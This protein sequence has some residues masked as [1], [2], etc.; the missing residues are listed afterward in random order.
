[1]LSRQTTLESKGRETPNARFGGLDGLRAIAVIMVFAYHLF[2]AALPGGFLGVDVFFTISGFLIAS[3]LIREY[4]S[5]GRISLASFWRRRARRLLPALALVVLVSTALSL[6]ASRDLL[7][8]IAKQIA[9]AVLFVSNWV[10]VASGTDYFER[11][12]PELFRNLWSLA[13][14]EQFY[15][16]LPLLALILFRFRSKATKVLVLTGF[17]VASAVLMASHATLG[18]DATRVYFGS[19]THSFGLLLG[20][21]MALLLYAPAPKPLSRGK[22]TV[23]LIAATVGFGVLG[24][25]AFTLPEASEASFTG[26]FQLATAAA[27]LIVGA[28]TREGAWAGRALDVQPLRWIGER[29]YGIYLWHWPLLLI[30]TSLAS[31]LAQN[32]LAVWIVATA[33]TLTTIVFAALSYR[34]VEQPVRQLGLR[35][36]FARWFSPRAYTRRQRNVA[37]ALTAVLAICFPLTGIAVAIAPE[38]S[39]SAE[40][41][42]RGQQLLEQHKLQDAAEADRHAA[43][44][45]DTSE[46]PGTSGAAPEQGETAAG[47]TPRT[48]STPEPQP[49]AA[50]GSNITAVGDSVMLAS[51]PELSEAFPGID[52][53]AAVSRG[54]GVGTRLVADAAAAGTLRSIL[55]VGLGT[56]GP[57][58]P[59]DLA[60]LRN[61]VGDRQIV[62][63][64]AHAE[65]DWITQVNA[66]LAAFAEQH[67][68]VVL[69][70]WDAAIA[71]HPEFLAGDGIHPG[72]DGGKIYATCVREAL[73]ELAT[74]AEAIGWRL[75]RR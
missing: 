4:Q 23:S 25:L 16:L 13:L 28:I 73:D 32:S 1:M 24:A 5:T 15:I 18:A 17:G 12:T 36:A 33:T 48:D 42:L 71:H 39:S 31:P 75:P 38:R 41:I 22:N 7:V 54:L 72:S 56:N 46:P 37:V 21:A 26:G 68:G 29:S 43:G 45:A 64:N 40:T 34:Y 44:P 50:V 69:A 67:R 65:R 6:T 9:G 3:L 20:A 60:A 53:D 74:P 47:T 70:D 59:A 10:F 57:V 51:F 62:L 14:E 2:P 61:L 58:D 66:D 35:R 8:G 11:D 30:F 27:L 19:D 52:V 63:V 55:V 49:I